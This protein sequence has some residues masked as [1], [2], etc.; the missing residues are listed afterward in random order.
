MKKQA[1]FY[2]SVIDGKLV[3]Q[4]PGLFKQFISTFEDNTPIQLTLGKQYEDLS[5]NQMRYYF[6]VII[7]A[8]MAHTGYA[9]PHEMDKV[10]KSMFLTEYAGTDFE[11]VK[12][13][14][15][16]DSYDMSDFIE[17]CILFLNNEGVTVPEADK[18]WKMKRGQSESK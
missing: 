17:K 1:V 12:S 4:C 13:K 15:D 16:L 14:E 3:M 9:T 5:R 10:F 7:P 8:G 6:G 2:G 11:Q 18:N